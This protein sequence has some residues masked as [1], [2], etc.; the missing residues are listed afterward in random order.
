MAKEMTAD[1]IIEALRKW[2]ELDDSPSA[3]VWLWETTR[4]M[5]EWLNRGD[6]IA[7][8]QNQD[9]GHPEIGDKQFV[10]FGS[11]AA[12]LEV[13]EPPVQLPDIGGRINWR[14][15]LIGTYKGDPLAV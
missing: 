11:D 9:L 7:V 3:A 10:S 5:N 6:G 12:Q 8:Y 4:K 1:E 14:Y 13:S 15:V 2:G